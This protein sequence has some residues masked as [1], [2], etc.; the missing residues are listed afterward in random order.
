MRDPLRT[1]KGKLARRGKHDAQLGRVVQVKKRVEEI[2]SFELSGKEIFLNYDATKSKEEK[3]KK[4]GSKKNAHCGQSVQYRSYWKHDN[5]KMAMCED[6]ASCLVHKDFTDTTRQIQALLT[7]ARSSG[8]KDE[9]QVR[10]RERWIR[11]IRLPRHS[12]NG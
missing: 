4:N 8:R 3:N 2:Y 6:H 10:H 7:A 9:Y 11:R 5:I 12:H 1:R